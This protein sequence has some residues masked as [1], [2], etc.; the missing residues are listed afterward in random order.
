MKYY[1]AMGAQMGRFPILGVFRQ[2]WPKPKKQTFSDRE[3]MP[4]NCHFS[5]ADL[6]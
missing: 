4:T 2:W 6:H 5:A 3:T 1:S